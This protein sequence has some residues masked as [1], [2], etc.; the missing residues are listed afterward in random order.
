M[1][2][3]SILGLYKYDSTLFDLMTLPAG[4]DADAVRDNI[5]LQAAD[6]EVLYPNPVFMKQAIKRWA[7][8]WYFTFDKW[9]TALNISYDPLNNFDRYE[10][11]K[12]VEATLNESTGST[13]GTST[14]GSTTA[15]DI[16]AYNAATMREDT[17][18]TVSGSGSDSSSASSSGSSD[19]TL[20]H[21]AHL[22]GNIGVTTSQQMLEAELKVARFNL[23]D[24]ITDCF[25]SE[26]CLL[27]Y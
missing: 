3:I 18:Q 27:V 22:Y 21:T 6:L 14:T 13:S 16:S 2:T 5:L 1:A 4:I 17:K 25:M 23:I 15:N 7:D 19:R 9:H 8:K 20:E 11:Y 12:D 24:Q 10:E 26:F